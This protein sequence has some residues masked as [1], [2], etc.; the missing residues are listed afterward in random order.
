MET[1]T[2]AEPSSDGRKC[3][4][5][6]DRLLHDARE[7]M[8]APTSQRRQ[9]RSPKRNTSYMALMSGCVK[10]KPS[11]FEEVVKKPVR[12]DNM[13][14][15]YDSIVRKNVWDVVPRLADKSMVSS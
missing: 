14:E 9:R 5:E 1:P 13:V 15:E 11:S 2:H 8:G 6:A 4:R 12:V 7:N 10:T 3:T